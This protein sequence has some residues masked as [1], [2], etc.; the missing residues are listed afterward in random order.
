MKPFTL[1]LFCLALAAPQ[2]AAQSAITVYGV[3]DLGVVSDSNSGKTLTKIDSGQQTASRLGFKG[4]ESLGNGLSVSFVLE[5]QIEADQGVSSY[6]GRIF[7]S[8]S[9]VA[10]NGGFG[11][12]TLGRMFTPYFGAIASNDPFD[13]K[14]PGESTRVFQDSGVRMDNTIK[15]SLPA[16]LHG[17]YG[18]LA[19]GAGESAAGN[20][21]NR[22]LSM[23]AGYAA[24]PLNV[25]LAC[26]DS[27]DAHGAKLARSHLIGASYDFGV[28]KAWM[29]LA[30]S[31]NDATLDTDDTLLGVSV[32][33]GRN[34]LAAD[35][36]HK[37]D[38]FNARADATQLAIGYYYT[39]SQRTNLY[40]I[41]SRLSND[42]NASYQAT[43]PG[44]IRRLISSGI[45]H[46]F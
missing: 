15:Y 23:D 20:R 44:G 36:V 5:S 26:H 17:L 6:A 12:I 24:G 25:V 2:V 29:V 8:Q 46:Q 21:A 37:R 7:S 38:R 27:N 33:F 18:D 42:A 34:M 35:Y 13:A 11:S 3:V 4:Q 9:W 1:A 28:A 45:R 16:G 39:L 19:Y 32:P 10:L 40:M 30:R 14:G 22:Q 41:G 31:R 43:L